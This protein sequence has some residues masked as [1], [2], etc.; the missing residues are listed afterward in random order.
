MLSNRSIVPIVMIVLLA[1]VG[2]EAATSFRPSPRDVPVAYDVDL[3][4][5]GGTTGAVAAA[6]EAAEGGAKVLLV[7]EYPYLGENLTATLRLWPADG[8]SLDDPLAAA[9]FRDTSPM[10]EIRSCYFPYLEHP[11]KIQFTY[12]IEGPVASKS[13]SLV[14]RRLNDG[15]GSHAPGENIQLDDDGTIILDF[16]EEKEFQD[17]ALLAFTRIG[18]TGFDIRA[19]KIASSSDKKRWKPHGEARRESGSPAPDLE[20]QRDRLTPF[21]LRLEKPESARYLKIDV[22]KPKQLIRMLLAEVV[23][24]P[25]SLEMPDEKTLKTSRTP[26][27][28]HVKRELDRRLLEAGIPFLYST[29]LN[30]WIRNDKGEITGAVVANKAGRQAILARQILHAPSTY[31]TIQAHRAALEQVEFIVIGGKPVDVVCGKDP[32]D[33]IRRARFLPTDK[34]FYAP[35]HSGP[36]RE[37]DGRQPDLE[38][39]EYPILKYRFDFVLPESFR[40]E[41]EKQAFLGDL[42]NRIRLATYSPEQAFTADELYFLSSSSVGMKE[43]PEKGLVRVHPDLPIGEGRKIGAEI[44]KTKKG[45][46][47][48]QKGLH[49]T[50]LDPSE[51]TVSTRSGDMQEML[52]GVRPIHEPDRFVRDAGCPWPVLGEYDVLVVGGGTSGAAAGIGAARQGAKTLVVEHLHSLGGIGTAGAIAVYYYGNRVGFTR[53]VLDGKNHWSVEEKAFWWLE[54]LRAAGGEAW[55]GTLAT[56]A[57]VRGNRVIGVAVSTPQ[58]PGVVFAGI[59][60]DSTGNGD[61]AA[62]AGSPMQTVDDSEFALQGAGLPPR[63]LGAGVTNTDFMYVDEND[64]LDAVHVFVYAKEKYPAAFDQGK[65]L[66]TRERRRIVGDFSITVLDEING[67]TY[68]DTIVQSYSNFDSHGYTT[69]PYMELEHPE[70]DGILADVPFRCSLPKGIDGL[71]VSGLATSCHRDALPVL[72]MQADLQNQGYALGYLAAKA[73]GE[74]K[75]DPDLR[76]IDLRAVQRHLVEIGNLKESVLK[77]TDNHAN[78]LKELPAAV[79]SLAENYKGANIVLWYPEQARSLVHQAFLEARTA[80]TKLIYAKV[81]AALGDPVGADV[82]I[83][84]IASYDSWDQGWNFRSAGQFGSATSPLDQ[85]IMMLGRT[86]DPKGVP[87]ILEKMGPLIQQDDFS[88]QRACF[89]ALEWIGD[90]SAAPALAAVLK[91]PGM[92]GYAH[93]DDEAARHWNT[94]LPGGT[95]SIHARRNS[96][97]EIGAARALFRCG[98]FEGLGRSIL[99][100]YAA[101]RRGHFARHALG[102]L[103]DKS[104]P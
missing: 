84:A 53:E 90:P 58:G 63:N 43:T 31:R 79:E 70:K 10:K 92:T 82:L 86:R 56:G 59:V 42:E 13:R 5:V 8:E 97:L 62:L 25:K 80:E 71:L 39:I 15:K 11:S 21:V 1:A 85:L 41:S 32:S 64:V 6:L 46:I 83:E 36:P 91:K 37:V 67:R 16:G 49:V 29:Y 50:P 18:T 102:V 33:P 103:K 96:L 7:S 4:V 65:L 69:D 51:R 98:D 22:F 57:I 2:S 48:A 87:V 19:V 47:S 45:S 88:H 60:I 14:A 78:R 66:D 34:T 3:L 54:K 40:D 73:V 68:P 35:R 81:A 101:D 28:M 93:A 76:K 30:A 23:V 74:H 99:E 94:T 44:S 72:R 38:T 9:V 77:E 75:N 17:I 27:P 24:L 26:R 95:V 61:I 104:D 20:Q 55:L 52:R 100:R 12:D 89:L